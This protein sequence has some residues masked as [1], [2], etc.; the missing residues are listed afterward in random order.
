[1]KIEQQTTDDAVLQEF[2][3]RLAQWRIQQQLTQAQLA[4]QAGISKRTL[5]RIEA[6]GSAQ[7]LSMVRVMRELDLLPALDAVV[8][9]AQPSPMDM[10]YHG[11]KMRQRASAMPF[12]KESETWSWGD[13]A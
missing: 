3:Q 12:A 7:M 10:L 6:G 11:G 8:P 2:G 5:E 9:E 1:M 4:K 13:D